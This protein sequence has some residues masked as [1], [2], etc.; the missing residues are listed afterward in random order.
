MIHLLSPSKSLDFETEAG[1][2][3]YTIPDYLSR[4]TSLI[5]K[6]QTFSV[7]GLEKLMGISSNLADLNVER[8][9]KWSAPVKPGAKHKQAILAFT[10]DVY[11]GLKATGLSKNDLIYAQEH[12]RILSGLYGLL[13]PLDLIAAYRLEMGTDLKVGRK[14]N[15][16]EFWRKSLTEDLNRQIKDHSQQSIINLASNEY[17]KVIDTKKLV[18]DLIQ[19]VFKDAKNG[20]YKTIAIYAKIA[21]GAMSRYII[22]NRISDPEDLKGFDLDNYSYNS[23]LSEGNKMVFT[24]EEGQFPK[25]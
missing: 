4:S 2:D 11:T 6:L 21:R 14:K 10:G 20:E 25:K 5:K 13:K 16:Y 12:L 24:R 17:F 18:A 7:K 23:R 9:K 15:L 22:K 8:Y 3:K 1:I 19:P